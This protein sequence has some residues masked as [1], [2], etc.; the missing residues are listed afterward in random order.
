MKSLLIDD[1][2]DTRGHRKNILSNDFRFVGI[3]SRVLGNK[4]RVV[5]VFHSHDPELKNDKAPLQT[6]T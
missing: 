4:I 5:M 6:G 2:V 3:G 1:G